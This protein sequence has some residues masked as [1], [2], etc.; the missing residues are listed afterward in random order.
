MPKFI[1]NVALGEA[2]S[3][4]HIPFAVLPPC[5]LGP[6][7]PAGAVSLQVTGEP[8]DIVQAAIRNKTALTAN[9]I[10][11][12]MVAYKIPEPKKG[13]GSGK[14]GSIIKQDRVRALVAFLFPDESADACSSL[15]AGVMQQKTQ[16]M[17]EAPELLLK[18]TAEV[19]EREAEH[20][21][22]VRRG[23]VEE[24]E[25]RAEQARQLRKHKERAKEADDV[26]AAPSGPAAAAE[27]AAA[28][29]VAEPATG[30]EPA[31]PTA[32]VPRAPA[33][34]REFASRTKA[35]QEF[36]TLLPSVP[37]LYFKWQPQ[38]RRAMVEFASEPIRMS[39]LC[40]AVVAMG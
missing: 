20:F 31:G 34:P 3:W 4:Q 16:D 37:F 18:L 35:P 23:A 15:V 11:Q 36:V 6:G 22:E 7:A 27:A 1:F 13:T 2:C 14:N 8:Q 28:A 25:V 40:L 26:R 17:S 32:G 30:D 10:K 38:H 39:S 12:L 9:Q 24:L 33:P 19:G 21:K 5:T 29:A